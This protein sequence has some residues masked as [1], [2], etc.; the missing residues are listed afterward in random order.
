MKGLASGRILSVGEREARAAKRKAQAEQKRCTLHQ[1]FYQK[2]CFRKE[3]WNILDF[4]TI[5]I[6]LVLYNKYIHIIFLVF[7]L[8]VERKRKEREDEIRRQ[9]EEQD[10]ME[11]SVHRD[12]KGYFKISE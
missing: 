9:H 5:F 1:I 7:R 4:F 10:R 2:L 12:N 6:L 11:R 8:E 3:Y